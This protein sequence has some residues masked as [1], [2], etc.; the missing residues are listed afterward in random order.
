MPAARPARGGTPARARNLRAQGRETLRRLLDAAIV[1]LG[2][3][4]YHGARIDDIVAEAGTSHG[5]F[6]LYFSSKEDLFREL[7]DDVS[8]EMTALARDL[9]AVAPTPG[10]R[11]ELREWLARF[12]DIYAHYH[13]VIRAWMETTGT[14]L[15]LADMGTHVV[16]E[17]TEVLLKRVRE[18]DPPT[19]EDP[20]TAVV[21]MLAMVERMCQYT[22]LGV[23][24][25]KRDRVLDTLATM[26][27]V[28]LFAGE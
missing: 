25:L 19:V 23:L 8:E 21:A 6:Y 3:R 10:G 1:V 13:P 17:I 27:H 22:V 15:D 16:G 12:Y 2:E 7:L 28:A 4:G 9:P 24:P 5:T 26:L 18:V 11:A 14:K 20:D